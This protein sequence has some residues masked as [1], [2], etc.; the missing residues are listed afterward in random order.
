MYKY[1]AIVPAFNEEGSIAHVVDALNN[2]ARSYGIHLDVVV[3]NDCS[4]D[5]TG[6]II[7]TLNCVALHLP[8]NLGIG[9]AV[10]TGYKYAFQQGYD[11]VIQVDGDGQHPAEEIPKLISHQ[12]K[13]GNNVVIGSRFIDKTGFQSSWLRRFGINYFKNLIYMLVGFKITDSTSGFRMLDAKA[14][15]LV[16][17][18]YP[19]EYPEPEAVIYYA[20]HQLS[21]GEVAVQMKERH[22]GTSSIGGHSSIYY[23]FKVTIAILFRF[24]SK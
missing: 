14:L 5:N 16:C 10:Q 3:V 1:A 21:I 7:N 8:N 17:N 15:Q 23:M 24:F 11:F 22:S 4:K 19:D 20:K 12:L 18:Y 9:G 2:F 6:N 13:F